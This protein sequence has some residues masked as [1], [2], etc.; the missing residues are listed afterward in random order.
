MSEAAVHVASAP[1]DR[2]DPIRDWR[3]DPGPV[4]LHDLTKRLQEEIAKD[5]CATHGMSSVDG[6]AGV[7]MDGVPL[8]TADYAR[9][10]R[11]CRYDLA[12]ARERAIA[13]RGTGY[14]ALHAVGSREGEERFGTAR[15]ERKLGFAFAPRFDR[16]ADVGDR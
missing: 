8:S 4:H 1:G 11:V 15:T 7:D 3:N 9:G 12:R 2:L 16:F 14:R 6:R 10:G 13:D 5:F